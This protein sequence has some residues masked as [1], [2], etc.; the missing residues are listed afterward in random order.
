MKGVPILILLASLVLIISVGF[1]V[2]LTEEPSTPTTIDTCG[3]TIDSSGQ[4][5][6][7]DN[8]SCDYN[9]IAS[10]A[11]IVTADNVAIDC[12][13]N[14]ITGIGG[15]SAEDAYNYN[16]HA[17]FSWIDIS[18]TG[19]PV[20]NLGDW[21]A[22]ESID[23]GFGFP[24]FGDENQTQFSVSVDGVIGFGENYWK[25][26]IAIDRQDLF[27][28][29]GY[30]EGAS[31]QSLGKGNS[32]DIN[33][34]GAAEYGDVYNETDNET[35][36]LSPLMQ[37]M[38]KQLEDAYSQSPDGK[39]NTLALQS[40]NK[41]DRNHTATSPQSIEQK[42]TNL[43]LDAL[44][45][46]NESAL[47]NES[48]D[49]ASSTQINSQSVRKKIG[50]SQISENPDVLTETFTECPVTTGGSEACTVVEYYNYHYNSDPMANAG[51]FEIVMY[52]DGKVLLQYLNTGEDHIR[53]GV[54]GM[55]SDGYRRLGISYRN[56]SLPDNSAILIYKDT[57][58]TPVSGSE[59]IDVEGS[60]VTLKNCEVSGFETGIT[61]PLSVTTN[62]VKL[63]NDELSN[64]IV[65]IYNDNANTG[66]Q[67][68]NSNIH[69]NCMGLFAYN[70][71]A[72]I[73][74]TDF[75]SNQ[76]KIVR[77]RNDRYNYDCADYNNYHTNGYPDFT[78]GIFA[79]GSN[80]DIVDG[81]F[82]NN[83]AA[84]NGFPQSPV[85]LLDFGSTVTWTATKPVDCTD[86][87]VYVDGAGTS[88]LNG[89]TNVN[90]NNCRV[91]NR[92]DNNVCGGKYGDCKCGDELVGDLT[93][94]GDMDC[95]DYNDAALYLEKSNVNLNC[96]GHYI[97]GYY[98]NNDDGM[99]MG[100]NVNGILVNNCG[101]YGAY[102]GVDIY[103]NS[104]D[105]TLENLDISK[106][107]DSIYVETSNG[108]TIK[109][110]QLRKVHDNG[111]YIDSG[112]SINVENNEISGSYYGCKG[113]GQAC[114][115]IDVDDSNH[116]II[117]NNQ[118]YNSETGI[119]L[120]DSNKNAITNNEIENYWD[121]GYWDG[122]ALY[123]SNHNMVSGNTIDWVD[124]NGIA[125]LFYGDNAYNNISDNTIIYACW[126]HGICGA[127]KVKDEGNDLISGNMIG[128]LSTN[129][130]GSWDDGIRL[131]NSGNNNILSNDISMCVGSAIKA[132]YWT[133]S[134]NS[135]EISGNTITD[136]RWNGIKLYTNNNKVTDNVINLYNGEGWGATGIYII[137]EN[138]SLS[139]NSVSDYPYG[140]DVNYANYFE[141]NNDSYSN[142]YIGASLYDAGWVEGIFPFISNS[143][144]DDNYI[145]GM[146]VYDSQINFVDN[147]FDGNAAY[148]GDLTSIKAS[149]YS[150]SISSDKNLLRTLD[151][152]SEPNGGGLNV[153]GESNAYIE[154]GEFED[155]LGYGA[156]SGTE[157]YMNL[158]LTKVLTCTNNDLSLYGDL[159]FNGGVI[160][161][162]NCT[163]T[164][165]GAEMSNI[166]GDTSAYGTNTS[167]VAGNEP[168]DFSIGN[169]NITLLLTDGTTTTM[170]VSGIVPASGPGRL[171]GAGGA[172][173]VVDTSTEDNLVNAF[174][175]I[176][177]N[178][179]YLDEHKISEN[180]LVIY[181][182]NTNEDPAVWQL[183][184]DQGINTAEHYVWA[185]VTHLSLFGIFGAAIAAPVTPSVSPSG[186]GGGGLAT[187]LNES[188]LG[189]TAGSTSAVHAGDVLK[190]KIGDESHQVVILN[191]KD[192]GVTVRIMS[193]P[194][195]A[196]LANGEEKKFDINNDSY[197]DL[198]VKVNSIDTTG[199]WASASMTVKT[200]HELIGTP[201]VTK[202]T[203]S[204]EI[205]KAMKSPVTWIVIVIIVVVLIVW[206]LMKGKKHNREMEDQKHLELARHHAQH[207]HLNH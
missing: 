104:N 158:N 21:S 184:P 27:S 127:I 170:S 11:I 40:I 90:R 148:L 111:I 13:N 152:E 195:T 81:N 197:Y 159:E 188:N 77:V 201:Q 36:Q 129:S 131:I 97:F 8:L 19:T 200:I 14:S 20:A 207:H 31:T 48:S 69:D 33:D 106:A 57:I 41:A 177:Y 105:I 120:G 95:S 146:D 51:T 65:G 199:V 130:D 145:E 149:K 165:N 96:N 206:S 125:S 122:I 191:I 144:V 82:V 45:E 166:D 161:A 34:V 205:T 142:N 55:R 143:H 162:T 42:Y 32:S 3:S 62:D 79:L 59:G 171:I 24:F 141:I 84:S 98:G 67:I 126:N 173:I 1:V 134:G 128:D 4:Y 182:Y 196:T 35:E 102:Y 139:G 74:N 115:G 150:N 86:N 100:G 29:Y 88:S 117:N 80:I 172:S 18:K 176:Y 12:N 178:K 43:T 132:L 202:P 17:P 30:M 68:T 23:M 44:N 181:Y 38:D 112:N 186:G 108:I 153:F 164:I 46:E 175:K 93:M 168:T 61:M 187:T 58:L 109:D 113:D 174:I 118:I 25:D 83:G 189:S 94:A 10:P 163:I 135:N 89:F 119:T 192:S 37:N 116:I 16:M 71:G 75:T 123:D 5:V 193:N 133:G 101:I 183:E 50:T 76:N 52:D 7:S 140:L 204:E 156:W 103:S 22:G 138:N 154:S 160:R 179:T 167:D 53:K 151:G 194:I 87:N 198:S 107:Y 72:T 169:S 70:L 157:D 185:N 49:R 121:P 203:I 155:N 180:S 47:F 91:V 15:N 9:S 114:Q 78:G 28:N 66:V 63:E 85:G 39:I 136:S 54:I 26:Y 137:G 64:N 99:S 60:N 110:S 92:D 2:S 73:T 190:F 6:L 56:I 124:Y 147:T